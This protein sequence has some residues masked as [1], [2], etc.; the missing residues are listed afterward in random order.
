MVTLFRMDA[1]ETIHLP[2][3]DSLNS[4]F[5]TPFLRKQWDSVVSRCKASGT[6]LHFLALENSSTETESLSVLA[7]VDGGDVSCTDAVTR[8]RN[9]L[10]ENISVSKVSWKHS[11]GRSLEPKDLLGTN[12][13]ILEFT[14]SDMTTVDS[15]SS[16]MRLKEV[17]IPH[18]DD[19]VYQNGE[20]FLS[21][22]SE[23]SLNRPVIGLYQFN[24]GLAMRPLPSA[25]EDR[26]LPAP[27]LVFQCADTSEEELH[28]VVTAKIGFSGTSRQGQWMVAHA[29]LPGLDLRL[30]DS[31]TFSSSFAE[32][33]D[34]LLASSLSELQNENVLLE[35]GGNQRASSDAMNG[36]GDCWVE[37][38]ANLKQP[39]GFMKRK[40]KGAKADKVAKVPNL[41]YE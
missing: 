24:N 26:S 21:M 23:S 9:L 22:L 11:L 27:S 10:A 36:A 29:D 30:T 12:L 14:D 20:T 25:K 7:V 18:Y 40:P 15:S 3:D 38:R 17:C 35:G 19:D 8:S 28:G 34:S 1:Q 31:N 32:A 16:D 39:S 2:E 33:Q 4:R 41:P 13:P 6:I 5:Q 37:F